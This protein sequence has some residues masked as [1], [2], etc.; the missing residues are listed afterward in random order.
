MNL[1]QPKKL[2]D[3]IS[4]VPGNVGFD[5]NVTCSHH[6]IA[7]KLLHLALNNNHSLTVP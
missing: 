2:K 4:L 5:L 1:N 7:E 6:D 3:V